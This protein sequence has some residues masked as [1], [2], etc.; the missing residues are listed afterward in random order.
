MQAMEPKSPLTAASHPN[1]YAYYESLLEGPPLYYDH[2]IRMWVAAHASSVCRVL[3]ERLCRVRPATGAVPVALNGRPA[4]EIFRHLVRMTDGARH[5]RPKLALARALAELTASELM[6]R[7]IQA[8]ARRFPGLRDPDAL[9]SW[10]YETPVAVVADLLGIPADERS[11][12]TRDVQ[13]FM[14]GISTSST[15]DQI[16]IADAAASRLRSRLCKTVASIEPIAG[17]LASRVVEH[18]QQVGW[19]DMECVVAN[20]IGLLSQ[21]YEATAGLMGN[22]MVALATVPPLLDEVRSRADGWQQLIHETSRHESPVQNTRRFVVESTDISG[23]ALNPGCAILL[24]LAAANR[25]PRVNPQPERFLLDRANRCVFTFSR[26]PHACPGE[27]VAR[28]IAASTLSLVQRHFDRPA[29]ERLAWSWK[30]STN[31]RLPM[32]RRADFPPPT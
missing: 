18:A 2:G 26:G 12:I 13:N 7:S 24:V 16:D 21:T 10:L 22:S 3:G 32:F 23:I 5:D 9:T 17:N 29:L 30:A 20:L 25:D 19:T 27:S 15:P 1:P 4:G 28:T 11:T 6:T 8:A 14:G 31:G